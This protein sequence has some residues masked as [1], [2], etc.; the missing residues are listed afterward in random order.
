[1]AGDGSS[2][3]AKVP[4]APVKIC[5]DPSSPAAA[6]A[7]SGCSESAH[8]AE[9]IAATDHQRD[10]AVAIGCKPIAPREK[11]GRR[12]RP[13]EVARGQQ[14]TAEQRREVFAITDETAI[15]PP[16][17][18]QSQTIWRNVLVRLRQTEPDEG[19]QHRASSRQHVGRRAPAEA[20]LQIA[21]RH[22]AEHGRKRNR[23]SDDGERRCERLSRVEVAHHRSAKRWPGSSA[24]RLQDA[25]CNQHRSAPRERTQE[26][27]SDVDH[28]P[29]RNRGLSSEVIRQG[30]VNQLR[31][32]K[33]H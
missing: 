17:D 24:E 28:E 23:R 26:T 33:E 13:G 18:N 6:P 2:P 29:C 31:S 30:S 11:K 8:A 5:S 16:D 4:A 21:A 25:R 19:Q 15:I 10:I 9:H 27:S 20:R 32:G 22:R 3:A 14:T 12:C 7:I 1:M